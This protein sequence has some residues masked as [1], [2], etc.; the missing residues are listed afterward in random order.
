M[1]AVEGILVVVIFDSKS[2]ES[3]GAAGELRCFEEIIPLTFRLFESD[4]FFILSLI[5]TGGSIFSIFLF[6]F[7]RT[8]VF[9]SS[10]E[11]LKR[12]SEFSYLV[13]G[14]FTIVIGIDLFLRLTVVVVVVAVVIIL[15][16]PSRPI[17]AN[18]RRDF[19]LG[20]F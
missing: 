19:F 9:S 7:L 3:S 4:F 16:V 1:I 6:F 14:F 12:S 17:L 8:I 13:S 15:L 2:F 5:L 11:S 10:F 18:W 20:F